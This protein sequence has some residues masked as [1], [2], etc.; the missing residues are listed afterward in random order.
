MA[1]G[2][3]TPIE[4]GLIARLTTG[5]RYALTGVGPNEWFGPGQPL[6][7][8][9]PA[10]QAQQ[11]GVA[12][13]QFDFQTGFNVISRP[14]S[15]EPITF[16]TLR[17]L[18]DNYDLLRLLIETRKDQMAALPWAI[19]PR[20]EMTARDK[21][22]D[23]AQAFFESPDRIHDW[24]EWLRIVLED[25]IVIDAPTIYKRRTNGGQLW[26]LEPID[27]ATIKPVIDATGRSP[28]D[29]PAYQQVLKGV[30]AVDYTREELIYRPRNPRVHKVYGYSPVEQIIMT[31][32]IA[33]RRQ[34]LT[35]S[36]F[37]EGSV[38]D[39]L[40]GVP[41]DW[42]PDQIKLF[43]DYWDLL[44]ASEDG[45]MSQRRKMRFVP[46]EIAKN[47]HE[48]KQPPLKDQFD[49]WLARVVCFAMSV[50]P[51]PFVA[52]VNRSVAETAREQSLSEGLAPYRLWVS[53]LVNRILADEFDAPDLHFAWQ[54]EE[55]IDAKT[56]AEIACAY[57]AAKVMHPDEVRADL[58]LPPLTP[59]QKAELTPPPPVM[60]PGEE[61]QA[62]P[63]QPG[64]VS[65]SAADAMH[66]AVHLHQGDTVVD[67]AGTTVHADMPPQEITVKVDR[68]ST[69][70]EEVIEHD[71]V[72]RITR[73]S[74]VA[75]N[76]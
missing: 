38:P 50:E 15:G 33:L 34:Q 28:I 1:T 24:S 25:M 68:D 30:P 5:M 48:T 63:G 35:L 46:G 72:G 69:P 29:G 61:E 27:G 64:K 32:S 65:K 16:Q 14:R 43:Q 11:Q 26:S 7:P 57:V 60:Q 17:A 71:D 23:A 76:H 55:V 36:Y 74:R 9:V 44:L 40:A 67:V 58:G 45:D 51:T 18:G 37:T 22:C 70:F 56:K 66:L 19:M 62:V 13:R 39:A 6:Q 47:F 21:R 59:E 20:D 54:D 53:S 41:T 3:R 75:S 8:A 73:V 42:T 31:I 12:G 10:E 49:E 4:P 52:Q 2:T